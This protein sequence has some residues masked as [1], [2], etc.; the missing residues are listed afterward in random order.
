MNL[1]AVIRETTEAFRGWGPGNIDY[2]LRLDPN[3]GAVRANRQL[4][5]Q[6]VINLLAKAGD[7]MPGGGTVT[8]ETKDADN[9][10]RRAD[11]CESEPFVVLRVTG[12]GSD[13]ST[14]QAATG[15]GIVKRIV[16]DIGGTF[17]VESA[18]G[19]A[20]SYTIHIPWAGAAAGAVRDFRPV[21]RRLPE[22]PTPGALA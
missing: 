14:N 20:T 13:L 15:F 18:Q 8:I 21:R 9:M 4:L 1:N 19:E 7:A 11:E 5:K 12:S 17:Q 2:Q 6:A 16:R 3:L 10:P 22:N